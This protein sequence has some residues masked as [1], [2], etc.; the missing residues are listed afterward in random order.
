[1]WEDDFSNRDPS[2]SAGSH[3]DVR[4]GGGGGVAYSWER[5]WELHQLDAWVDGGLLQGKMW[6]KGVQVGKDQRSRG[7]SQSAVKEAN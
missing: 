7:D 4:S 2:R 6:A 5:W 1:M 3:V